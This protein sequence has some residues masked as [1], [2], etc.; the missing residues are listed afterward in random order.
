MFM[1]KKYGDGEK[2]EVNGDIRK[3][4]SILFGIMTTL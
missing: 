1:E 2:E 4:V 3:M